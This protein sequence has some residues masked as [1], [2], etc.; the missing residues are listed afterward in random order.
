MDN[1]DIIK[2]YRVTNQFGKRARCGLPD[3]AC[4]PWEREIVGVKRNT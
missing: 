3:C 1:S 4:V 2:G